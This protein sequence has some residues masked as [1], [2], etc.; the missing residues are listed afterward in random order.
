MTASAV[1]TTSAIHTST[2]PIQRPAGMS[3]WKY[4]T[5]RANWRIGARYCSSPSVTIGTRVAAAPKQ[6]SGTA[7]TMPVVTKSSAWPTPCAPKLEA[8]VAA[9]HPTYTAANGAMSIVSR[10]RLST[11]PTSAVFFARP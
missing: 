9:S 1:N 3:S 5:P 11:A 7:V 2:K 8:P 10:V 4:R 6:I